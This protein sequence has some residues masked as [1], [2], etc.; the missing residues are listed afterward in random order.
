MVS[1]DSRLT[2][3][4]KLDRKGMS[5]R[6]TTASI[7]IPH[8]SFV[9]L[10][11]VA[12]GDPL[13]AA[14][15]RLRS[16]CQPRGTLVLLGDVAEILTQDE[17]Q[18]K[19]LAHVE[20]FPTPGAGQSRYVRLR[21]VLEILELRSLDLS[22]CRFSGASQ[23]AIHGPTASKP[24][25]TPTAPAP[26]ET[27]ASPPAQPVVL[28]V[29]ALRPVERGQVIQAADVQLV[30]LPPRS[31]DNVLHEVELAVGQEAT[32]AFAPGQAIDPRGLRQP[33]L[34]RRREPVRVAVLAPGVRLLAEGLAL[35]DGA[36]D[37]WVLIE[38]SFSQEKIRARV[39][40]PKMVEIFAPNSAP[41]Q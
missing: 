31:A 40:G 28:A 5:C 41:Q 34:V 36:A 19:H 1:G 8:L 3:S 4:E 11:V 21:E 13:H 25:S 17:Q 14:E 15:V 30:P 39:C 18:A 7:M 32:R 23:T 6:H 12:A 35:E 29:A 10:T 20:L 22:A 2:L 38:T 27:P 16:E 24:E 26:V 37:D 9:I 33:L